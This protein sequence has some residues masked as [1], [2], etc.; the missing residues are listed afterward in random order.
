MTD[1]NLDRRT[2]LKSLIALPA[3]AVGAQAFPGVLE[4]ELVAGGP[5][6]ELVLRLQGE[7]EIRSVFYDLKNLT[8]KAE[9]GRVVARCDDAVFSALPPGKV[10]QIYLDGWGA[11]GIRG[12]RTAL[13]E[14][15]VYL[16]GG[17]LTV[18]WGAD[19]V[20]QVE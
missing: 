10:V 15:P 18:A 3:L 19:G 20:Y 12:R 7:L 9:R 4:R 17:D 16:D 2:F 6:L 14:S 1:S 8:H 5:H 11:G 13:L